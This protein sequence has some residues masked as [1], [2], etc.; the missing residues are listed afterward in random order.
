MTIYA[1]IKDMESTIAERSQMLHQDYELEFVQDLAV[2]VM[3]IDPV[4][5]EYAVTDGNQT[6]R[7]YNRNVFATVLSSELIH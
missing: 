4:T 2:R 3:S 1:S 7:T 6:F 5:F